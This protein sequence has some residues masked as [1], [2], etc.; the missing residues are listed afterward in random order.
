MDRLI[1]GDVG[2]GKTEVAMRAAFV[3]AMS[4]VQV[5]VIAPRRC[6]PASTTR[7]SPTGSAA[8]PLKVRQLSRFVGQGGGGDPRAGRGRRRHRDRHPCAAGQGVR[9]KNLGLLIIDEEQHF[10]VSTRSG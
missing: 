1:C 6:S 4:G 2:F 9:F 10:G 7:A 3:A 8:F 5:A